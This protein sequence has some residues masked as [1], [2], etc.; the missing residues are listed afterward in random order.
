MESQWITSW[1]NWSHHGPGQWTTITFCLRQPTVHTA[2]IILTPLHQSTQ[3]SQHNNAMLNGEFEPSL[4][5]VVPSFHSKPDCREVA[6][7][8]ARLFL[9]SFEI[10]RTS[11]KLH[12]PRQPH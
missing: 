1:P 10:T 5:L 9:V 12:I 4:L 3:V 7:G 8:F 6:V 11:E 2:I